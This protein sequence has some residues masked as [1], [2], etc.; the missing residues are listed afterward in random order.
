M[1]NHYIYD[2]GFLLNFSVYCP[3]F[4]Q[5]PYVL[6][7]T[8]TITVREILIKFT[9]CHYLSF[10]HSYTLT[11]NET[12]Q[13]HPFPNPGRQKGIYSRV[14]QTMQHIFTSKQTVLG[15]G[16]LC[17]VVQTVYCTT[18]RDTIN[19]LRMVF[20]AQCRVQPAELQA[21]ALA[22]MYAELGP[23]SIFPGGKGNANSIVYN[24]TG[25][26]LDRL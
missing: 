17:M 21:E 12:R 5:S 6:F 20:L 14:K 7:Q 25:F 13:R 10:N 4:S 15:S 11:I 19:V 26:T 8:I 18:L 1:D 23:V 16:L 3:I 22:G 24:T 2:L 9:V